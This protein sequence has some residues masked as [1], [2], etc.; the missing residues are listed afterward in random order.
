MKETM[1]VAEAAERGLLPGSKGVKV[2]KKRTTQHH[3]PRNGA[4]SRCL[5][6]G[7]EFTTDAAETRHVESVGGG[8]RIEFEQ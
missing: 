8:H 5:T 4:L 7:E 6:H 3:E 2:S 1:T